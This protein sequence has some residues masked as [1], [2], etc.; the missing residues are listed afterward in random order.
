MTSRSERR[1]RARK[2]SKF[3]CLREA[4]P[5]WPEYESILTKLGLLNTEDDE[6]DQKPAKT[7]KK[8]SEKLTDARNAE[9]FRN[10]ANRYKKINYNWKRYD[11]SEQLRALRKFRDKEKKYIVQRIMEDLLME[12]FGIKP[13]PKE[14]KITGFMR[15]SLVQLS[16]RLMHSLLIE[17]E[18]LSLLNEETQEDEDSM[19]SEKKPKKKNTPNFVK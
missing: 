13:I 18:N 11:I 6:L 10:E 1:E 16:P 12:T 17:K 5:H 4:N 7:K 8:Q 2:F 14:Q 19:F 3:N 15:D 9:E